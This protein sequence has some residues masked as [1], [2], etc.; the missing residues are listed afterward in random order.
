M[1]L[2][3]CEYI[4]T[5]KT[6]EV[7]TKKQLKIVDAAIEVIAEKGIQGFTI[8]NLAEKLGVT[9]GAIYR[10]FESKLDIL[11]D[12]LVTFRLECSRALKEARTS[13]QSS[14]DIIESVFM[15]HFR[16]FHH[17]PAVASVLF[18]ESIFRNN[19]LLI[20]EVKHLLEMHEQTLAEIIKK[21]QTNGE[22][23]LLPVTQLVKIIIG[24]VRYTVVQWRLSDYGFDIREEGEILMNNLRKLLKA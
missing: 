18:A 1:L 22:I 3:L 23:K 17:K 11:I 10:H 19:L 7:L 8:K 4:F 24:S 2:F 13:A 5:Y 6:G 14:L 16:H 20:K 15:H 9:E 21:G 12:I